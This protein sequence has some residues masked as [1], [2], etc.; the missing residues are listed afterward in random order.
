MR[1]TV[2][3]S[4]V[5]LILCIPLIVQN[6]ESQGNS[7]DNSM[8]ADSTTL[9]QS[10]GNQ[11]T[12]HYGQWVQYN[13]YK[14]R[15]TR[16]ILFPFPPQRTYQPSD[17]SPVLQ[18]SKSE[19]PDTEGGISSRI[20]SQGSTVLFPYNLS[21]KIIVENP[22]Y[23][24]VT[25]NQPSLTP[26][27]TPTVTPNDYPTQSPITTSVPTASSIEPSV[28]NTLTGSPPPVNNFVVSFSI[29]LIIIIIILIVIVS[30][31]VLLYKRVRITK[32]KLTVSQ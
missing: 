1:K 31:F 19:N 15:Y 13:Q 8:T 14:L 3:V 4:I 16:Q 26:T 25:I 28:P 10:E 12:L 2:F 29:I 5:I 30:I 7:S 6:V 23:L 32:T 21:I 17:Y 24:V 27:P 9:A 20:F 18:V 11:I 22:D